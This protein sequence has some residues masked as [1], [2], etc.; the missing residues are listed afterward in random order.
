MPPLSYPEFQGR[1]LR[2]YSTGR[3][4]P[5][6]RTRMAQ[7][8]A[9]LAN[10]GPVTTADLTTDL[11]AR[12]VALK[13]P[14]ANHNTVNGL[15]ASAAAACSYALDEGWLDR[16]PAW[17]RVRL[18]P[19]GT[20]QNAPRAYEEMARLLDDLIVHRADGWAHHRLC[21]LT[22][23]IALTGL[24]RDEALRL[25]LGDID[26]GDDP[27]LTVSPR[28][29]LKTES[30]ARAVPLPDALAELLRGWVPWSGPIWLFPG[31]RHRG[32]W[33]GGSASGRPL[34]ALQ[35]AARRVGID[36]VTWHSMRH[37]FGTYGLERWGLPV[38]VVQRVM[39]H[40]DPRT[41]EH[42]LHLDQSPAIAA[43]VRGIGYRPAA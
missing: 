37:A 34:G 23:T 11:M 27:S 17:R 25:Q 4:A 24:R 42:Y 32:P 30:S 22:W 41:T 6:T 10:L 15:L 43:A 18:R 3:H 40:R 21:A 14:T 16:R 12:W 29:R 5:A 35:A 2:L 20:V 28:R 26:L 19:T 1:V 9:E 33:T 7:V 38:W 31:A 36:H 13:G 8:L 39:G